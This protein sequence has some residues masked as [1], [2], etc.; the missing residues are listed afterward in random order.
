MTVQ[1][2]SFC[3]FSGMFPERE[4]FVREKG[5]KPLNADSLRVFSSEGRVIDGNV[6]GTVDCRGAGSPGGVGTA[7]DGHGT[8]AAVASD[9]R[10]GFTV[11]LN[12]EVGGCECA[13]PCHMDTAGGI[14]FCGDGGVGYGDIA[15]TVAEDTCAAFLRRW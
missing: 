12:G 14:L 4:Q 3:S 11:C 2:Q 5:V 8:A 15:V 6:G 10:G 7:I 9:R 1:S 13:A